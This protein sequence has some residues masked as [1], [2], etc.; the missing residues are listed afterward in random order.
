MARP[1]RE[2]DPDTDWETVWE[3]L[4]EYRWAA[5]NAY[6]EWA[7]VELPEEP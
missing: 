1:R 5:R 3:D 7:G 6:R 2:D 4:Q